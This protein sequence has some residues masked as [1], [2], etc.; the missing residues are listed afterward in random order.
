MK[1]LLLTLIVIF[2]ITSISLCAQDSQVDGSIPVISQDTTVVQQQVA[3]DDSTIVTDN[4]S[5]LNS[6]TVQDVVAIVITFILAVVAVVLGNKYYQ[7]KEALQNLLKAI[8]EAVQDNK[9]SKEQLE[10][11]IKLFKQL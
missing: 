5:I 8:I 9:I 6:L 3:T 2:G 7:K 11:I 4:G 10:R 1:K